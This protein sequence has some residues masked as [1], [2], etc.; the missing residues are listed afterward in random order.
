MTTKTPHTSLKFALSSNKE[1]VLR[2][3]LQLS[4]EDKDDVVKQI[5]S[6]W[7]YEKIKKH[8]CFYFFHSEFEDIVFKTISS[9]ANKAS[10]EFID[11]FVMKKHEL[12][13]QKN[14][15]ESLENHRKRA[16]FSQ[17]ICHRL[18]E[19]DEKECGSAVLFLF[20]C[21]YFHNGAL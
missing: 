1:Y 19:L 4:E 8:L 5:L 13:L 14:L 15:H 11:M 9:D 10:K 17:C 6:T 2:Q 18:S 21:I 12:R 16:C 3:I 7:P 20:P